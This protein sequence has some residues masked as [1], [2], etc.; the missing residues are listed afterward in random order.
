MARDAIA[1]QYDVEKNS[2][3]LTCD[4]DKGGYRPGLITFQPRKGRSLDLDKMRESLTATRLSGGTNMRMDY[5]E[6]TARGE[7]VVRD[8][9]L[10]LKVSGTGEEFVLGDD[11]AGKGALGRLRAAVDG[12]ARVTS[13]TGRLQGWSG[14]FPDVLKAAAAAA[15]KGQ[16]RQLGV[17]GFEA[18]GK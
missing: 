5:L 11:P 16:P 10:L 3:T 13:V 18:A 15:E 1:R 14:R 6:L 12:G 2:V 9:Q 17:V 8:K 4:S 7:V